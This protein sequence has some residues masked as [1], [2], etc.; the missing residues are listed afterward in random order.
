MPPSIPDGDSVVSASATVTVGEVIDACKIDLPP[1]DVVESIEFDRFF[2][3]NARLDDLQRPMTMMSAWVSMAE[4]S[5]EEIAV[6]NP[7][8]LIGAP[9]SNERR[10]WGQ[11]SAGAPAGG[12]AAGEGAAAGGAPPA[13]GAPAGGAPEG[14]AGGVPEGGAGGGPERP[15]G[16]PD[17]RP[18]EETD[19]QPAL[20]GGTMHTSTLE[21]E[22]AMPQGAAAPGGPLLNLGTF[23]LA[24]YLPYRQDWKLDGYTRGRMVNSLSLGP[25]EEQT[26][27]IFKWDRLV[28]TLDS[29]ASFEF[30]QTSE[31]SGTRRDTTDI[32]HEV[33]KQAGF[34]LTSNA[35]VGFKVEMVNADFSGGTNA[36]TGLNDADKNARQAIT[37]ATSRAATNVRSSRTLKVVETKEAGEET[38][39]TR[40]LRN[41]NNCHTLTTTFFEILANYTVSTYLRTDAIRLVVLMDS[42]SLKELRTFD[43]RNVR[44]HERTL[45]MALLDSTLLPGFEAARYLDARD[46]ACAVLCTGCDC[47][48]HVPAESGGTEWD[49]LGKALK[50]LGA[51][52]DTLRG[53]R[54]LFPL[55]IAMAIGQISLGSGGSGARDIKRHMFM[56][57]LGIHAPR[58]LADLGGLALSTA[59]V[60][61]AIANSAMSVINSV[62]ADD[63]GALNAPERGISDAVMWEIFG[64]MFAITPATDPITQSI[65]VAIET[66]ILIAAIGGLGTFND[67][68]LPAAIADVKAKFAA[69]QAKLEEQRKKDDKEAEL[70]RI[71]KEERD[72]RVLNAFP[73]RETAEA[74]E[75]LEAL[76]D[77]LNDVRN[78]DHYRF[79]VW[80]ERAGATDP[81]LLALAL[82]GFTEGAP[83]GVVGDSLAVPLRLPPGSA[84]EAFFKGSIEDLLK[85]SP[86][87]DDAHIL[88]TAALYAE[89]IPGVCLACEDALVKKEQLALKRAEIENSLLDLEV[90]RRKAR[91]E[92][93][94]F[95]DDSKPEPI[96]VE[97]TNVPAP[98]P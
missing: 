27:E 62:P 17:H 63:L 15:G 68:G 23:A 47:D 30:E 55:S 56:K 32:S 84:L 65:T 94:D 46:R 79:A 35:K 90:D 89:A 38:R 83:V 80:N 53:Y 16:R 85:M 14:A 74:Q 78:L 11:P 69:W 10:K 97:L 82:G 60:T 31:S 1:G 40:K 87:D 20:D 88:P 2:R 9:V 43:R 93:K 8:F 34:E 41:H 7:A 3:L 26:I 77:H 45:I 66:G 75:R 95:G 86:R 58:L 50:A 61:P 81:Q 33:T 98:S 59:T 67:G 6:T 49:D 76:L 96:R 21:L 51:A 29:T 4:M 70:A 57:A 73:L 52:V 28:R 36:K 54:V 72:L 12:A 48:G 37:E 42:S 91:L 71:A 19:E 24:F 39:V 64:G 25:Q 92:A 5:R 44:S 22:K 18:A 13:G